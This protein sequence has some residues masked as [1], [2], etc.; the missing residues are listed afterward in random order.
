MQ[1]FQSFVQA[2]AA[3]RRQLAS[4][5]AAAETFVRALEELSEFVPAAEINDPHVVGDLDFLIDS[6]HLIANSHQIWA[7]MIERD[8]EAPLTSHVYETAQRAA[9]IREENTARI[10]GSLESIYSE[11]ESSSKRGRKKNKGD[12]TSLEKS[13]EYRMGLADEIKRLTLENQTIHDTLSHDSMEPILQHC[14]AGVRSELETYERVME[15]LKKLGAYQEIAASSPHPPVRRT[16]MRR[17]PQQH[18]ASAPNTEVVPP[19]TARRVPSKRGMQ[20][21]IGEPDAFE[22]GEDGER[23][24]VDFLR[25]ALKNL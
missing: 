15:G 19:G 23:F 25:S 10:Q 21:G 14:A 2:V 18:E 24:D 9:K 4:M 1:Q 13:L 5:S 8:F 12:F 7:E 22:V 17:T 16:T 3:F 6:T 11:E 20:D